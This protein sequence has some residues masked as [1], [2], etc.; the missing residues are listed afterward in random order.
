TSSGFVDVLRAEGDG[1]LTMIA[2]LQDSSRS[3]PDTAV[4][5]GVRYRYQI[6]MVESSTDSQ[7]PYPS[8]LLSKTDEILGRE[9]RRF[10]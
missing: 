9:S 5:A 3:F 7:F 10:R 4:R 2:R 6:H 8:A 1:P